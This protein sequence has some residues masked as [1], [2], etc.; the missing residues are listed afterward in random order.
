MRIS[1]FISKLTAA[2]ILALFVFMPTAVHAAGTTA[3]T[4]GSGAGV[5]IVLG[6]LALIL[7]LLAVVAVIGAVALGIIGIGYNSIQGDD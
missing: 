7:I 3:Q 2:I 6:L 5:G 4:E 1:Q